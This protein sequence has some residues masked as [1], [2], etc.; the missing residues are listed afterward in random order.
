MKEASRR[1]RK[2]SDVSQ[3]KSWEVEF[4]DAENGHL[5]FK[6]FAETPDFSF[7]YADSDSL[8]NE[9]AE[10]YT[11]SEEPEFL[12]NIKA[13]KEAFYKQHCKQFGLMFEVRD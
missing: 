1:N 8:A 12:W 4:A 13:F 9:I 11:Y 3:L 2:D 6:T 5:L 7:I 10:W